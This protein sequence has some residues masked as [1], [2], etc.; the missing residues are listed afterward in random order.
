MHIIAEHRRQKAELRGILR[1]FHILSDISPA[2]RAPPGAPRFF[3]HASLKTAEKT[4][5]NSGAFPRPEPA[6]ART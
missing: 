4:H 3:V 2:R 5:R 1:A 6:A